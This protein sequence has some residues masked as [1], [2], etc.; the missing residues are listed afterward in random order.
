MMWLLLWVLVWSDHEPLEPNRF[1]TYSASLFPT[2]CYVTTLDEIYYFP[3]NSA[4]TTWK[5]FAWKLRKFIKNKKE[6]AHLNKYSQLLLNTLLKHLWHQLQ[7]QIFFTM[8]LQARHTYLRAVS[9][10]LLCR[11]SQAQS[12]W[13]GSVSAQP[14]SDLSRDVQSG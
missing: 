3:Q 11:T 9:P 6:K 7:H 5:K 13:M 12:S 14:F 2:F 1:P 8:M 10:S 4:M